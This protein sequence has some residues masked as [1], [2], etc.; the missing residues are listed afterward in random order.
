M[1]FK[2]NKVWVAVDENE[3]PILEKGKVLIKYQLDQPHQYWVHQKNVQALDDEQD[4]LQRPSILRPDSS[5][6]NT[7]PKSDDLAD[8][9]KNKENNHGICIFT[10][11]ACSGNPGPAGIGIVM[12]YQ[13][14]R[15]E[16]SRYIGMATNNIAELEAIRVGLTAIKNRELPITLYT[17]SN[18]SLGVLTK[19]WKAKQN[20]ALI[21]EIRALLGCFKNLRFV[22]VKGHSGHPENECADKLAVQA[23]QTGNQSQ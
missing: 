4:A 22:K 8:L 11:G 21:Q 12:L 9:K 2:R 5:A 17:D 16:I 19:G 7:V 18:Y 10:D 3:D 23:I 6:R 20:Q 13:G 1:R 14:H 15:K